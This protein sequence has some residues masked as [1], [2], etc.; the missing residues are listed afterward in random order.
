MKIGIPRILGSIEQEAISTLIELLR[1][2]RN[3]IEWFLEEYPE[4]QSPADQEF[5]EKVGKAIAKYHIEEGVFYE[6]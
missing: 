3:A 4:A 2:G 1:E 5:L 6:R